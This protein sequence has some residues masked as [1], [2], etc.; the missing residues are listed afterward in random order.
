MLAKGSG[1]RRNEGGHIFIFQPGF[2]LSRKDHPKTLFR[3]FPV[4]KLQH[5]SGSPAKSGQLDFA[6]KNSFPLFFVSK[7]AL[8]DMYQI[9]LFLQK[10]RV[11][12]FA[13]SRKG[14]QPVSPF[15][16]IIER[17]KMMDFERRATQKQMP[18]VKFCFDHFSQL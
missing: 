18:S 2:K 6:T 9:Y 10:I 12:L 3:I 4:D 8:V 11:F 16:T 5:S 15:Q 1:K 14:I 17:L 7:K 13:T